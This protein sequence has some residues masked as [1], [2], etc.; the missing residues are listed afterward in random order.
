MHVILAFIGLAAV[1]SGW[2][3]AGLPPV[4]MA[5]LEE[6]Y[7]ATNGPHWVNKTGWM[8]GD[9]CDDF[10]FGVTCVSVAGGGAVTYASTVNYVRET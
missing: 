5:A 10:W 7:N 8:S 6:F 4:Q 9:P 2:C 3:S 1:L